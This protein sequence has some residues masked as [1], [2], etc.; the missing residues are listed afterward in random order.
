M[1][2]TTEQ[3]QGE[4]AKRSYA[5]PKLEVRGKLQLVSGVM[6]SDPV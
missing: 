3:K 4:Q 5:A 6:G 1:S 2:K